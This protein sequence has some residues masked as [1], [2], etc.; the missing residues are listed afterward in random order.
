MP[1]TPPQ[2]N[3]RGDIRPF[4]FVS[5]DVSTDYGATESNANSEIIG[6]SQGGTREAPIPGAS[7]NA[8]ESGDTF[9]IYG[10]GDI[11]RLKIGGTVTAG[12]RLISDADGQGV[13]H[14]EGAGGG[15]QLDFIGGVALEAGVSG[16]IIEIQC[17]IYT[18]R[19]IAA[20]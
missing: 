17:Q 12:D 7:V 9:R 1:N 20:S 4:R 8:A 14:A 15:Q 2:L 6:V 13:S 10:D 3:A 11:C 18:E 5:L 19:P 16:D